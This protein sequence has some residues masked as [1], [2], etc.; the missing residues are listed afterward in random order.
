MIVERI[1]M[2]GDAFI[3]LVDDVPLAD[4]C[5]LVDSVDWSGYSIRSKGNIITKLTLLW[6]GD[7][8]G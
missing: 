4:A 8:N 5:R 3:S 2:Q 6:I 7:Y 1:V